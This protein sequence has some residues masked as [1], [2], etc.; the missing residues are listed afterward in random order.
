MKDLKCYSD[1]SV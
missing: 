1:L